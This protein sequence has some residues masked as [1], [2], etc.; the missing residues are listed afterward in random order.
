MKL[1]SVCS[2]TD[3]WFNLGDGLLL[4][5]KA[6]AVAGTRLRSGSLPGIRRKVVTLAREPA[7]LLHTF[8]VY[9]LGIHGR[10]AH[11]HAGR[12]GPTIRSFVEGGRRLVSLDLVVYMTIFKDL[13]GSIVAPWGLVIQRSSV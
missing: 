9:A 7:H 12:R 13:M 5:R 3:Q 8:Q 10:S 4:V 1:F 11:T 6:A 2:L